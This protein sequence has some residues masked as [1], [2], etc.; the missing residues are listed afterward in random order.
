[1]LF[2]SDVAFPSDGVRAEVGY[3]RYFDAIGG[4]ASAQGIRTS[5]DYAHSFGPHTLLAGA[6]LSRPLG[7]AN[8]V[9]QIY[10]SIGGF[11]KLSGF[12]EDIRYGQANALG[13]LIYYRR[14]ASADKLFDSPVYIGAT[15]ER[16]N[17]WLD[18]ADVCA[19]DL[20]T[21]GSLFFGADTFFG[22]MYLGYGRASSG[23]DA[24]YLSF[25]SLAF[26]RQR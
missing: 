7:N 14:F 24:V 17:A 1:M 21:A 8:G 25:G 12:S 16:G 26:G 6:R 13:R 11:A 2:R 3:R 10:D 18:A 9:L 23:D 20:L 19:C 5:I 22:P 15:L 4:T